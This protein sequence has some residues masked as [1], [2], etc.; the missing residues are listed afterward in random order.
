MRKFKIGLLL[1]GLAALA[2][3]GCNDGAGTKTTTTTVT[4]DAPA[5][6]ASA[7]G[8]PARK[9]GLW[10]QTT[11]AEGMGSA[12]MNMC[13]GTS[14][15]PCPGAKVVR[16]ADGYTVSATCKAGANGTVAVQTVAKG[17][18]QSAYTLTS[19]A[20]ITDASGV[21]PKKTMNTV[22]QLHYV[23]PCPDGM[24]VGQIQNDEGA[25]IDMSHFDAAKARA[26]AREA[27]GK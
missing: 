13:L 9:A 20:I 10:E 4:T 22:V 19:T 16:T 21:T 6:S 14:I 8:P 25:V 17:D 3:A 2:L 18:L 1:A 23:G 24:T 12:T 27:A 7:D 15:A 26:L 11:N 5:A